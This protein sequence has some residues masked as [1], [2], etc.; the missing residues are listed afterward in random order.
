MGGRTHDWHCRNCH[1]WVNG[2][3]VDDGATCGCGNWDAFY[4]LNLEGCEGGCPDLPECGA[5]LTIDQGDDHWVLSC[6]QTAG[7][8][9]PHS[10]ALTW[11]NHHW[12]NP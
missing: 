5:V 4:D 3:A 6:F 10:S 9:S 8:S 12:T 7:H 2:F 1:A 11:T